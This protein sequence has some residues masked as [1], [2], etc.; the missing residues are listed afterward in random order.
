LINNAYSQVGG[1]GKLT[2]DDATFEA[3]GGSVGPFR[4]AVLYNNSP[5]TKP[6][7]GYIDRGDSVT[8]QDGEQVVLD[9]SAIAG[10][11][12]IQ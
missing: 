12:V 9:A 1:V 7:I 6:L 10:L 2:V 8:L 5:V 4:Y 3:S 11:I